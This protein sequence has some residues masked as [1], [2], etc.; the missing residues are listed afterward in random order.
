M[1]DLISVLQR[2]A[3]T[4]DDSELGEEWAIKVGEGFIRVEASTKDM[5]EDH[6]AAFAAAAR[7]AEAIIDCGFRLVWQRRLMAVSVMDEHD[8]YAASRWRGRVELGL[9]PKLSVVA[10]APPA[11]RARP[12][13]GNDVGPTG[14]EP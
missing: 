8:Q 5:Y 6:H 1:I 11:Q 3:A 4:D 12:S 7:L 9:R 10:D 13:S 14:S 2:E